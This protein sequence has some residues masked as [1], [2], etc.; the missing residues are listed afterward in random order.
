MSLVIVVGLTGSGKTE[1]C[2]QYAE[3]GHVVFDDYLRTFWNGDLIKTLKGGKKVCI[4]DPRL[5]DVRVFDRHLK[6]FLENVSIEDIKV[7]LF[8]NEPVKCLNNAQRRGIQTGL[9]RGI[10]SIN[11][12]LLD[13]MKLNVSL[14]LLVKFK[15]KLKKKQKIN[16]T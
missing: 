3:D 12:W 16:T 15:R 13:G 11:K 6:V 8:K 14:N 9:Q 10:E 2:K 7:V 1:H 4:N 5:C